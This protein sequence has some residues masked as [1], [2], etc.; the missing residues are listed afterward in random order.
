MQSVHKEWSI[1]LNDSE[2]MPETRSEA[3]AIFASMTGDITIQ[4]PI[5]EG[6]NY[7]DDCQDDWIGLDFG[8]YRFW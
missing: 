3:A 8:L 1:R 6:T 2:C 7:S 5:K 4:G